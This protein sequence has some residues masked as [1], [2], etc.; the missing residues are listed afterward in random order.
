VLLV[1]GGDLGPTAANERQDFLGGVR[2]RGGLALSDWDVISNSEKTSL[3]DERSGDEEEVFGEE[4]SDVKMDIPGGRVTDCLRNR[5]PSMWDRV[6]VGL[7]TF[8]KERARSLGRVSQ[9]HF[10]LRFED[11]RARCSQGLSK[12]GSNDGYE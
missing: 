3:G 5:S 7:G 4:R 11:V 2:T 9:K 12:C 6:L 1:L 8:M 10:E